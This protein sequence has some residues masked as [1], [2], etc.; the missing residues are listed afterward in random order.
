MAAITRQW[1]REA[2]RKMRIPSSSNL[3][4]GFKSRLSGL[5][6]HF[7]LS[8]ITEFCLNLFTIEEGYLLLSLHF[9]VSQWL[10]SQDSLPVSQASP[11]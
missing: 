10:E 11:R 4:V 5:F 7:F 1:Q 6:F 9:S 2:E 8:L 3:R